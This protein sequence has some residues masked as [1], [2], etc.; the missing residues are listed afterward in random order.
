M[1]NYLVRQAGAPGPEHQRLRNE[2]AAWAKWKGYTYPY[3]RLAD[4]VIPDVVKGNDAKTLLFVGDAKDAENETS[5]TGETVARIEKYFKV[6]SNLLGQ[7]WKGGILALATNDRNE[8]VSWTSVLNN[9]AS[10]AGLIT[11]TGDKPNF[12]VYEYSSNTWIVWW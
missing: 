6:F 12:S 1:S 2:L 4:E 5:E 11:G 8:A 3:G 10:N 9:A 7:Q